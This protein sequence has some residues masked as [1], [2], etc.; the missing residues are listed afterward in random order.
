LELGARTIALTLSVLWGCLALADSAIASTYQIGVSGDVSATVIVSGDQYQIDISFPAPSSSDAIIRRSFDLDLAESYALNALA[1]EL[2]LGENEALNVARLTRTRTK[3]AGSTVSARFNVKR[4]LV[5]VVPAPA[6][7]RDKDSGSTPPADPWLEIGLANR[8][9]NI[10]SAIQTE[11][12]KWERELPDL[13]KVKFDVHLRAWTASR[14]RNLDDYSE[15]VK[16]DRYLL[17]TQSEKI[18][19]E[20]IFPL[21]KSV[22]ENAA[23]HQRLHGKLK[24]LRGACRDQLPDLISDLDT[25]HAAQSEGGAKC[26]ELLREANAAAKQDS[27]LL[28]LQIVQFN[29]EIA[30]VES[31]YE[32]ARESLAS[33]DRKLNA[34]QDSC[35]GSFPD[36]DLDTDAFYEAVAL[37]EEECMRRLET[38]REQPLPEQSLLPLQ[39][40]LV[41]E[42]IAARKADLIAALTD[43]VKSR[44]NR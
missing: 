7:R 14:K 39:K 27:R 18:I 11:A 2:N 26:L 23:Q 37:V 41:A 12:K 22:E 5:K 9:G 13:R 1:L 6:T 8:S 31:E 38:I 30:A 35:I 17:P 20:T 24:E 29:K 21:R 4:S 32:D 16:T 40:S 33:I 3:W 10:V 36:S 42:A 43:H 19:Q 25:S 34:A 28:P 44:E 15:K